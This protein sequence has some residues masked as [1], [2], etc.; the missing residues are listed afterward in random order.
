MVAA[1]VRAPAR[2][3][4]MPVLLLL[5][6]VALL[7]VLWVL[8]LPLSLFQRYRSGKA[9]RRVQ[10]WALRL[11]AVLLLL[12]VGSLLLTASLSG[13]WHPEW[14]ASATRGPAWLHALVGLAAGSALGTAGV[15][16]TRIERVEGRLYITPNRWLVLG[17]T[18]LVT[19]RLLAFAWQSWMLWQGRPAA[20]A[21]GPYALD[22]RSLFATG[23]LLLGYYGLSTIGILRRTRS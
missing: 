23:G 7:L 6:A 1:A 21:L 22:G 12:S 17:L 14:S 19:A 2:V 13:L 9:R 3:D 10:R 15:W 5:G 4:L 11:N 16:L 8:L 18:L 20:L